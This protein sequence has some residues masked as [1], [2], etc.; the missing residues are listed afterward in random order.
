M[1]VVLDGSNKKDSAVTDGIIF[2]SLRSAPKVNAS[3]GAAEGYCSHNCFYIE[4]S[5]FKAEY[6]IKAT[7][8][9][10]CYCPMGKQKL[11]RL[12]LFFVSGN[13][14]H[15]TATFDLG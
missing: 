12:P 5:G 15:A 6:I 1:D 3:I 4:Q 11:N 7:A 2:L 13:G 9:V 14:K 8:L 10:A